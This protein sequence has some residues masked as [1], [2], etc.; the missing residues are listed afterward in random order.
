MTTRIHWTTHQCAQISERLADLFQRYYP[1]FD[2]SEGYG[3]VGATSV[4]K[5]LPEA[6]T[7]LD[8]DYHRKHWAPKM[9]M[10]FSADVTT[11]LKARHLEQEKKAMV[12]DNVPAKLLIEE[13][14]TRM[15]HSVVE[16]VLYRMQDKIL[17]RVQEVTTQMLSREIDKVKQIL[18]HDPSIPLSGLVKKELP[19]YAV[20]G[21]LKKQADIL[22]ADFDGRCNFEFVAA[23]E[24]SKIPLLCKDKI[25]FC[26]RFLDRSLYT[27]AKSV[28]VDLKMVNGGVS[29]LRRLVNF[30]LSQFET[31]Q[32]SL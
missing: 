8:K 19:T 15:T 2:W 29:D 9:L 25:T 14:A 1:G 12:L 11:I 17:Q 20:L 4:K 21:L 22:R 27:K 5:L 3:T 30:E 18:R 26:T 10:D 7:V 24:G 23:E 13:L 6:Q 31:L 16:Q 28:A 32:K